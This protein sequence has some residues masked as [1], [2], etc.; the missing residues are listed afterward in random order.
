MPLIKEAKP[1]DATILCACGC[2]VPFKPTMNQRY[3]TEGCRDRGKRKACLVN[4]H[5]TKVLAGRAK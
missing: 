4:Y 5:K 2:G 3:F 1:S